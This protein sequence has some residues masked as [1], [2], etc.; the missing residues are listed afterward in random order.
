MAEVG[1]RKGSLEILVAEAATSPSPPAPDVPPGPE[2]RLMATPAPPLGR[3]G[4][5]WKILFVVGL[6]GA[7]VAIPVLA[8]M[9]KDAA[10]ET[11]AGKVVG[12]VTDPEAPGYQ[13]LVEPTPTLMLVQTDGGRV[14]LCQLPGAVE[15]ARPARPSSSRRQ[16]R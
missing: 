12:V 11:T 5:T 10:L 14:G 13:V 16:P 9:G 6:L 4:W 1:R 8:L 3:G 15:H 7:I 2:V